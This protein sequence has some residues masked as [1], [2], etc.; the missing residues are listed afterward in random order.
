VRRGCGDAYR[1]TK[2]ALVEDFESKSLLA[3]GGLRLHVRASAFRVGTELLVLQIARA[4]REQGALPHKSADVVH[5]VARSAC[6]CRCAPCQ[7]HTV[8]ANAAQLVCITFAGH[9]VDCNTPKCGLAPRSDACHAHIRNINITQ[10]HHHKQS[11]TTLAAC[12]HIYA[13][14]RLNA[15]KNTLS[16]T[17]PAIWQQP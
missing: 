16:R 2:M 5:I 1:H 14:K 13:R 17:P 6:D 8:G 4:E 15:R 11:H 3:R 12:T 9:L 7:R 10:H